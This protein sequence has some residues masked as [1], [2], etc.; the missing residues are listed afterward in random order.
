MPRRCVC[1]MARRRRTNDGEKYARSVGHRLALF[2]HLS[3]SS[4]SPPPVMMNGEFHSIFS[5][6]EMIIFAPSSDSLLFIGDAEEEEH[7]TPHAMG[8]EKHAILLR[9]SISVRSAVVVLV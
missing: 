9:S 7:L 8:E 5:L 6:H 2:P 3:T 4:P 1:T